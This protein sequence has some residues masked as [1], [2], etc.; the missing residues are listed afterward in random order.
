MTFP[1]LF[2]DQTPLEGSEINA[3]LRPILYKRLR[4]EGSTLRS[5]SLEY[6]AKLIQDMND[7]VNDISGENGGKPLQV[8][9]H[10]VS[11]HPIY[12]SLFP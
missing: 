4:I 5:R 8:F 2:F 7:V 11:S 12:Y 1:S 10:K 9:I 3:S 6:Q